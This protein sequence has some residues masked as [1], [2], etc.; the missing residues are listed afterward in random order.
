MTAVIRLLKAA[1]DH[2]AGPGMFL[3]GR[4]F[5]EQD[6]DTMTLSDGPCCPFGALGY[7]A[8]CHPEDRTN[9]SRTHMAACAALSFTANVIFQIPVVIFSD[10]PGRTQ[11]EIVALFD[12]AIKR[13]EATP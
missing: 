3:P 2:I 12:N 6:N 8:N 1:R 5:K 9:K 7:A 10:T 13:L 4:Y 11:P